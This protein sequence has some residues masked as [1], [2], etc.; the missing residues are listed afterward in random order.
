M[1]ITL[2]CYD[3]FTIVPVFLKKHTLLFIWFSLIDTSFSPTTSDGTT[4]DGTTSDGT[5]PDGTTSDVTTSDVTTPVVGGI[6]G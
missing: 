4:P 3:A 6:G 5:T 2:L 1:L